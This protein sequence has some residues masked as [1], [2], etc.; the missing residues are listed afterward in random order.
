MNN[1]HKYGF[2]PV[3]AFG[4]GNSGIPTPYRLHVADS[5]QA[6]GDGGTPNVGLSIGD[7]VLRVNDGSIALAT[8]TVDVWGVIVG[9]EPY[10]DGTFMKP[11]SYLP[12]AT[13]GG[14]VL[15]RVSRALVVP[16]HGMVFECDVD[17]NTT[18]TTYTAYR[19]FIG[20]NV[21][22]TCVGDTT[23]A[24]KPKADPRLDISGHA[25]TNSLGWN[26]VGISDSVENQD[27]SGTNVKLY[28]VCNNI[29]VFDAT[30][31]NVGTGI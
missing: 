4:A 23:N 22:H 28:V 18:A 26:I 25:I 15:D 13:T 7:P 16:V 31:G 9:F 30:H 10:W 8:T 21:D 19:A 5:Y 14:S 27:F 2:R 6:T 11:T 20:E 17:E 24:S 3:K 1:T 29:Q 12:G